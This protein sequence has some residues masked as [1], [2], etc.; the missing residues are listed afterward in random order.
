MSY[1][2][3]NWLAGMQDVSASIDQEFGEVV[4]IIPCK[5]RPNFRPQ[6]LE[7]HAVTLMAVF[8]WRS[9]MVLKINSGTTTRA[10][11]MAESRK[12]VFSF[13]R[14]ALPWA[15]NSGDLIRR[16]CSGDVFEITGVEPDG[17]SRIVARTTQM[18][19]QSQ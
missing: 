17:V 9:L 5:M 6:P 4:T 8:S 3:T 10:D 15:L 7:D 11:P 13:S 12:P 1:V 19:R 16:E 14:E 2:Q 18:G